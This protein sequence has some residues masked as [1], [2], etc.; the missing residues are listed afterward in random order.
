MEQD[1]AG[2]MGHFSFAPPGLRLFFWAPP[3]TACA[4]GCILSPLRGCGAALITDCGA[5][6]VIHCGAALPGTESSPF[7][8]RD[9]SDHLLRRVAP[10]AVTDVT[11]TQLLGSRPDQIGKLMQFSNWCLQF[12]SFICYKQSTESRSVAAGRSL[13]ESLVSARHLSFKEGEKPSIVPATG[14]DSETPV[15]F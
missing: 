9:V 15:G 8:W 7:C 13:F 11:R 12:F 6:L 1:I 10:K 4:V 2:C 3:P 14:L 5:A